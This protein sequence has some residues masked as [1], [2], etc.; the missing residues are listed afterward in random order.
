M[1]P[2]WISCN[3]FNR[4]SKWSKRGIASTPLFIIPDCFLHFPNELSYGYLRFEGN[5]KIPLGNWNSQQGRPFSLPSQGNFPISF[6]PNV[7]IAEFFWKMKKKPSWYSKVN[8]FGRRLIFKF[9]LVL[10]HWPLLFFS[11]KRI[12][13]KEC[14]WIMKWLSLFSQFSR[15]LHCNC[16]SCIEFWVLLKLAQ[17]R[18]MPI[19]KN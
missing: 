3:R 9:G 18:C 14:E 6:K 19:N 4:W 11:S 1:K 16:K 5:R 10:T 17:L 2:N 7:A 15:A 13:Q 12:K 8:L